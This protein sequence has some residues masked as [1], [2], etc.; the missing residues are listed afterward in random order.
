MINI[1]FQIY[2]LKILTYITITGSEFI[3]HNEITKFLV[4]NVTTHKLAYAE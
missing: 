4:T 1:Y 2:R 3:Q